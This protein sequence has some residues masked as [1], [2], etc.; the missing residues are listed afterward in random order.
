MPLLRHLRYFVAV[1]EER[2]FGR[3][4]RRLMI[5]QPG[6]SQQI[7]A[8]EK[9]VGA[10]LLLRDRRSV[11]LTK[12]GE[13]LFHEAKRAIEHADR[14]IETARA[15]ADGKS[16]LLKIGT[17]ALG[18]FP[19]T[20]ELIREFQ[21]RHPEVAVEFHPALVP[22]SIGDLEGHR[23]DVAAIV[24]LLGVPHGAEYVKLG[25]VEPVVA[26]PAGYALAREERIAPKRLVG[27]TLLDWPTAFN[28][29]LIDQVHHILFG[30]E[31]PDRTIEVADLSDASRLVRVAGGEGIAVI[32]CPS[33]AELTIEGVVFR[34][35]EDPVPQLEYGIAWFDSAIS[36]YVRP[37]V[38]VAREL[39]VRD[40]SAA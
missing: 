38:D 8:L 28:P 39:A 19:K 14:S 26:I 40:G 17:R 4:A 16:G 7:K 36:P 10:P 32:F 18:V 2:H 9:T 3:A 13:A 6:L 27:E 1:A 34:R 24:T 35:L 15:V 22:Q 11:E 5:A 29:P 31:R 30:D 21:A 25:T 37:F 23:I 33:V 20:D 12:A